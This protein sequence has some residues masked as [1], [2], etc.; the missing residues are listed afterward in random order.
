MDVQAL[1]EH[2]LNNDLVEEVL[3]EIGCH[4][5]HNHGEYITC[6]NKDGDNKNAIVTYL[7]E[8]LTVV[9]Y[10]RQIAKSKRSTD[11]FDL[12]CYNQDCTFPG[13]LKFVCNLFGIDYYSEPEDIPE[14]LQILQL[15][16]S[17]AIDG[18]IDD[19]EPLKP[20]S[21]KILRY[22][23]PYGNKMFEDD[24]ISLEIQKEFEVGYDPQSNYLTIPIRDAIGTLIGIK[25]RYFGIPDDYHSKYIYL[26]KCNKSKNLYG[27]FQNQ[28]YIKNSNKI[29]VVE[30]E[31]AVMQLASI[32]VRNVVSTG[33]KT[34]SKTQVELISRTGCTPII[35]YD[36]D[37][38][39]D[40]LKNIADM[41]LD[42]IV[43]KA[44]VDTDNVLDAK[45]SPSDNIEKWN[46]LIQNNIFII[47]ESKIKNE[48]A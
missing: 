29:Y 35:S 44:I 18:D 8:N 40:E 21:E 19:C 28:N 34:I 39:L 48:S 25:G 7:N 31:K 10:T 46:H 45:E 42:G 5:I 12:I 32:G 4:S 38:T 1:K 33:G 24:G 14:S 43:V 2:L 41:F 20:I 23:L 17:M 13:A 6:A 16:K 11:I 26:E 3:Q 15:L 9:N 27:Y 30:S 47:K 37:V 22:Y 36:Q